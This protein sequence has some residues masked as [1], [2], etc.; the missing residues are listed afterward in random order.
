VIPIGSYNRQYGVTLS[1]PS[2]LGQSGVVQILRP[3][4]S[5][6]ERQALQRSADT[7]KAAVAGIQ[8]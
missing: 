6:D 5:D 3:T 1:M 4:M 2:V 7:L 8:M